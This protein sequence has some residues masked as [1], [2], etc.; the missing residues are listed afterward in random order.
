MQLINCQLGNAKQYR[1][2][3]ILQLIEEGHSDKEIANLLGIAPIIA[4]NY[5]KRILEKLDSK[6]R[7]QAVSVA[8]EIGLLK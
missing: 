6:N 1:E 8:R 3:Q 7:T 4:K 5:V 2:L